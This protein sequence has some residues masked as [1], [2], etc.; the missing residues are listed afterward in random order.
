MYVIRLFFLPDGLNNLVSIEFIRQL[1]FFLSTPNASLMSSA[2][3]FETQTMC[4]RSEWLYK[5]I[6]FCGLSGKPSLAFPSPKLYE[7]F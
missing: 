5:S 2:S 1:T 7:P 4:L 6:T 3:C